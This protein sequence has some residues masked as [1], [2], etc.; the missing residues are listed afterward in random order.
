[1]PWIRCARC[2]RVIGPTWRRAERRAGAAGTTSAIPT[3]VHN[4]RRCQN[5]G[6]VNR[7][8]PATAV[9]HDLQDRLGHG[10]RTQACSPGI[11]QESN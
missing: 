1:M 2:W 10:A 9:E 5:H 4:R 11:I 3:V 8:R 6:T 7:T